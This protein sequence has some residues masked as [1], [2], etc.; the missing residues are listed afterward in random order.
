MGSETLTP[1]EEKQLG[2]EFMRAIRQRLALLDDPLTV[3]YL[4]NLADR[5]RPKQGEPGQDIE[6][7]LVDDPTINAFAGPGGY[8]GIHS[9]LILAARDEGELA[10]V[11][12]HEI[13]H[14]SQRH[15][16]R[17]F[18]ASQKLS[19][20]SLGA[21]IAGLVLGGTNPELTEAVIAS[22]VAG[23]AQQ[24]LTYSRNHEQEA[25]RIGLELLA[26]AD[27]DPRN[28]VS[29]FEVLQQQ[30][31]TVSNSAPEFL[32]THPLTLARIADTRNRASQYPQH[33]PQDQTYFQLMQARVAN[34]SNKTVSNP[35]TQTSTAT[36][37][38]KQVTQYY[39]SLEA[40]K[41]G[42][43]SRARSLI[44]PLVHGLTQR[45]L[46]YYS[47][48]SLELADNKPDTAVTI[49][50]D[51]LELFPGNT[52]L[53]E[54]QGR[55]LLQM[56]RPE[57][58]FEIM[59]SVLRQ[60]PEQVFLYPTYA[61]AASELGKT[62]EAYRALGEQQYLLGNVHQSIK[63]LSQALESAKLEKYDR[64][65]IEARLRELKEEAR[66]REKNRA[67]NGQ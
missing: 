43:Y 1:R 24:H 33:E 6:V 7:F 20:T 37:M 44:E 50:A 60:N 55:A 45:V 16:V 53:S 57:Q 27:F 10:S 62:A 64:I 52:P 22:S 67:E 58:A 59:Q 47:A 46:Y 5:L 8:I 48:A 61:K 18:E 21:I 11:M 23:S 40:E 49:T 15:L 39:Q 34:L 51:A 38:N 29:F 3:T 35:F 17:S 42:N 28:M 2:Q 56:D 26:T 36:S 32:M 63:Y 19:L 65:S 13:A 4:Q 31:R 9:G 66:I 25:D 54:L 41:A 30:Q 14:V 12:A